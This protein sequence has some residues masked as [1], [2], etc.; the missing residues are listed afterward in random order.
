M[1]KLRAIL[2]SVAF[3]AFISFSARAQQQES[4]FEI[5]SGNA[6]YDLKNNTATFTN[7]AI[8]TWNGAVLTA[9][10]GWIDRNTGDATA[11]GKVRIQQDDMVWAGEHMRFNFKTHL[12]N[13]EEF[14]AGKSPVFAGGYGLQGNATNHVLNAT[15]AFITGDDFS[16]PAYKIRA[17][18]IK[19]IPGKRIEA[20]HATILLNDVPV[21]YFPYFSRNLGQ[22]ANNF[23]FMPGYRSYFGPFLLSS[24]TWFLND[25]LDGQ[26][27][28]DYREKRGAAGGPD[29]NFHLGRWGDGSI[30]Y[31]YLKDEDA[32]TNV[33]AQHLPENR[34]R[35][36]FAYQATPWTNFNVKAMT[37][38]QS[39][40]DIVKTFFESEYREDPQPSTFVEVNKFWQNFSLDV[41]TQP[42]VDDFYET[43]ERLPDVRLT[44]FR[45]QLGVTP[46]YYESESSL[47]Y[48]R[49]LFAETNMFASGF[50]YE[51]SRADTYHQLVLPETFFGW[52]NVTPRVGGRFTYYGESDG[53]GATTE[54]LHR[55]VFNTGGEVSFKASRVWPGVECKSLD[56][57]GVRHIIEPSVNYV[58]V[59][60]PNQTPDQ[61]PAFD[62]ELPS[63]RLLPIEFPEYN[64]IDSIDSQ[65]VLRFGLNNKLQTKRDG[66]VEDFLK[67]EL[68]TDWRLRPRTNQETFADLYSDLTFKPRSWIALESQ[69]RYDL[70]GGQWRMLLHTLTF[71]PNNVWSW[72]VGHFYLR[73]D[74]SASPTALGEGNNLITS[75]MFYRLNE[76][77]G[78]RATH[79][80]D[81]RSGRMEEQ[82]YTVY[83]DFRSWTA[84]ITGGVRDNGI[85][86]LDYGI[87]FSF[88]LK[89]MPHF[90][91]G[92]DTV[93]PYSLLGQ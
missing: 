92:S 67:W 60:R 66:K 81:A 24:Y 11:D 89:A 51:A 6:E 40:S 19:I 39:D 78:F 84:A 22:R 9:D 61:L 12:I 76:N 77:W 93:R 29:F 35:V 91:L 27:H 70:S 10:S 28:V 82:Y 85:G 79:N 8:I 52:L 56:L 25:K 18:R 34:Q 59:P 65:N 16:E 44:G 21:F 57:D 90:A 33:F 2:L 68:M 15:N 26:V 53:P 64:S 75:S 14:R 71:T 49:R 47:G 17:R 31:Y 88:S 55:W 5:I 45:Q 1:T 38:W 74:L 43:V 32:G 23:T 50:N 62:Y 4:D 72:T 7:G 80:F 48:Y 20:Y 3:L 73:D 30:R 46:V 86:Q 58:Y 36:Y 63:L 41:L 69:T 54:E 87:A 83:R 37:R 42:R 13:T